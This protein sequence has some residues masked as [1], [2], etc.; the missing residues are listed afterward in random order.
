MERI[1]DNFLTYLKQEISLVYT[2]D[3]IEY[4]EKN[5][6]LSGNS[7]HKIYKKINAH[8][9]VDIMEMSIA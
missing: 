2:L 8:R 4:F 6:Y 5:I 1:I 3:F 9:K 7:L